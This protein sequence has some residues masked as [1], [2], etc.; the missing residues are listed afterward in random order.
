MSI[1]AQRTLVSILFDEAACILYLRENGA[2][3][4][5]R[6]CESCGTGMLLKDNRQAFRCPKRSCRKE[7]SMW[8]G[9]FFFH[10]KIPCNDVM[11]LAYLWIC[12]A[13]HSVLCSATGHTHETVTAFMGYFRELVASYVE[14][15]GCVIGGHGVTIE[16]DESK[17]SKRKN[18]RGHHVE[19]AWVVG[20]VE[21]TS[22]KRLFVCCVPDRTAD[23]LRQ[24]IYRH[25]RFGTR[26]LTDCWRA[27]DW[28]D[29]DENF[30]HESVNHSVHFKVP[31]TDIHT[32]SIEGTW[33][34]LKAS[35]PKRSRTSEEVDS[36]LLCYIWRRQNKE[37][38]WT[39]FLDALANT[40]FFD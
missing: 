15:D 34:G 5:E 27:Y 20:G 14:E 38:L 7:A 24:V 3:Y 23:T 8:A 11:N 28:L 6:R 16:I 1:P 39:A 4:Q 31:N 35:I 9:S 26:I 29:E 2:L 22:E 10:C 25:V 36:H 12:G 21:R 33:A 18:N 30:I 40:H 17:I 37:R 13:T 19:G 32:N